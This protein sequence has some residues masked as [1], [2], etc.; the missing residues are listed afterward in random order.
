MLTI[1]EL[2]EMTGVSDEFAQKVLDSFKDT[3]S[4]KVPKAR[5]DEVIA[6][7]NTYKD[8]INNLDSIR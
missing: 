6:E 1:E 4:N 5:L 7:R 3:D 8:R 2:K